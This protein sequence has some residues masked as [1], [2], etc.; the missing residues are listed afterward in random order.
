[1]IINIIF[2]FSVFVGETKKT[3]EHESIES[4]GVGKTKLFLNFLIN[5]VMGT[6]HY[7]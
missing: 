2:F 4:A 6:R 7:V 1:M 3:T 5:L